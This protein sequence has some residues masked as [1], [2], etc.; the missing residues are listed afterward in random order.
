VSF[1]NPTSTAR[2]QL[3]NLWLLKAMF[4][5]FDDGSLP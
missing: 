1:T 2:L 5:C 4:R 3:L